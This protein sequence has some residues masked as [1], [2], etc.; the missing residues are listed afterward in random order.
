MAETER[1]SQNVE[2]ADLAGVNQGD[3]LVVRTAYT[4]QLSTVQPPTEEVIPPV[5]DPQYV[6]AGEIRETTNWDPNTDVEQITARS[7]QNIHST[8]LAS[9]TLAPRLLWQLHDGDVTDVSDRVLNVPPLNTVS[10]DPPDGPPP[11]YLHCC[12]NL[13]I[14]LV[15]PEAQASG[16]DVYLVSRGLGSVIAYTSG[17]V[18]TPEQVLHEESR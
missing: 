17:D 15:V 12:Q 6:F 3:V 13:N 10:T 2:F 8:P 16:E 1:E 7:K 18:A 14:N 9:L 11:C 4:E 5:C